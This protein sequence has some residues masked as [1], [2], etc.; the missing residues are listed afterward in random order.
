MNTSIASQCTESGTTTGANS[1]REDRIDHLC[2]VLAR[3]DFA[4]LSPAITW[5]LLREVSYLPLNDWDAF[6]DS[7][8]DLQLDPYMAD[9]GRYRKRRHATLSALPSSR[10][11]QIGPHQPHYQ[12]LQYNS[13]NGGIAR[14]FEPI[15]RDVLTGPTMSSLVTL[16]CEV[17][18]RLAPYYP[19]HIEVHQFRIEADGGMH[20]KPTPEGIHRDGVNYVMMMLVQRKNLVA[21]A[22]TVYD[23]DKS[24]LD[25]FTLQQ[26]LEMAIV[27]DERVYHGVT[28]IVQLDPAKPAIRDVLVITFRRR[29]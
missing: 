25:E 3:R 28:P 24:R 29:F 26:P 21:G 14:H 2:K 7:W 6:R 16:G 27:N 8:S 4:C 18:G 5:S 13:L 12:S 20:G 10:L 17:F 9:G 1:S 11:F 22:T 15:D 19:W 23:L